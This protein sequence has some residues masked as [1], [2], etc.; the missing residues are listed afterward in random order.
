[1][2]IED[3]CQSMTAPLAEGLPGPMHNGTTN[4][5]NDPT[6]RDLELVVPG[7]A[8]YLQ[9]VRD[10]V[11]AVARKIG[12]PDSRVGEIEIAVDEACANIIEHAYGGTTFV[13]ADRPHG[14]GPQPITVRVSVFHNRMELRILDHGPQFVAEERRDLDLAEFVAGGRR[15]GI[16]TYIIW[17]FMDEVR[18]AYHPG[19]GNELIL[20]KYF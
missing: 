18:H 12:L 19:L 3:R 14:A 5:R 1:M 15:R 6:R 16:G 13:R 20:V 17:N 8:D 4:T 2:E 10:F 9:L 7:E 11:T